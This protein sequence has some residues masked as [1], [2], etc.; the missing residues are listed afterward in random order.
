MLREHTIA[1]RLD[2]VSKNPYPP[3]NSQRFGVYVREDRM[4]LLADD[5]D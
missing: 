1:S 3:H 5:I 4:P 2:H